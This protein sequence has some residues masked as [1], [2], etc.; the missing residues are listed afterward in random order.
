MIVPPLNIISVI[1]G[2]W[3][4]DNERLHAMDIGL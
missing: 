2:Q 4:D 3:E 1:P